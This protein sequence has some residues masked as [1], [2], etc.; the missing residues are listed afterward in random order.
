MHLETVSRVP[1]MKINVNTLFHSVLSENISYSQ[2]DH[3]GYQ[4][5]SYSFPVV[6]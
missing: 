3:T 1:S 4:D 6:P 2:K 5:R